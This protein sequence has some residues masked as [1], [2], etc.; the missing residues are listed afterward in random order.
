MNIKVKI[1]T[2]AKYNMQRRYI[3]QLIAIS[4]DHPINKCLLM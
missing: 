3:T 2:D 1:K 4:K